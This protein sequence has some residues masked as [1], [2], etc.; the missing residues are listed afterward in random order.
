MIDALFSYRVRPGMEDRYQ[1]YLDKVFPI[2]E[3]E[4]PYVL[5]Y[6]IFHGDDGTYY[7]H[8][9]YENEDAIWKHME[10]TAAGQEDFAS[11]AELL[12]NV[13]LGEV[14]EKFR[15]TFGV[16]VSY[17]PFRSVSR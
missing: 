14:S 9:Q 16:K 12:T 10:R 2:T 4:E 5:G 3:A 8:E 1:A 15:D 13:I 11:S 7:Q 17:T 6:E